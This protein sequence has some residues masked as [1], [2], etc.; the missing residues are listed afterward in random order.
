MPTKTALEHEV[1]ETHLLFWQSYA[2]RD[3]D[4]RFSVC[5]DDVTFI[6]TGLHERAMNKDEYRKLNAKGVQQFPDHFQIRFLWTHLSIFSNVACVESEVMWSQHINEKTA[7]ELVRNTVLL[8][9]ESNKWWIV[10]VHGSVPDYRL[11][12]GEYMTNEKTILRNRELEQQVF[13]RTRELNQSLEELKSTQSQLIQSEKMASLGELT[14]GIAHEIQNPLNFVNNFSEVNIE[15]I[16]ELQDE[17]KKEIRDFKLEEVLLND[18]KE[19]EKKIIHHGKRADAIVKGM[20]QHSRSSNGI[21]EPTNINALA[22]EYLL[23][24]YHGFRAKDKLFNATIK[25]EYDETIGNINIIPQDIGRVI[26]NLITNAFYAVIEKK[27]LT[28]NDYEPI[29]MVGTKLIGN[30]VSIS[31]KD[32]GIGIPQ[33]VLD[34]IFQPFFTTRPAG[35]G[36]GLGLSLAFDIVTKGHGGTIET[37]NEEG[38]GVQ[39][40]VTIPV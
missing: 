11:A 2:E 17:R 33:K 12:D 21:K 31:I 20:L 10:H 7:N 15:L 40:I 27:N 39:M 26:L 18:I 37:V 16:E 19:N 22:D 3:L 35:Q 23:L 9:Y 1:M 24:A 36:T 28:D 34:K 14:A 38:N 32:N 8:K 25:T 30:K 4:R 6:G 13:E 5:S 29:V